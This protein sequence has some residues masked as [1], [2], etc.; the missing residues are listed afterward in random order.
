MIPKPQP[1]ASSPYRASRLELLSLPASKRTI[2]NAKRKR[3][4]VGAVYV[5]DVENPLDKDRGLGTSL[6]RLR[7]DLLVRNGRDPWRRTAVCAGVIWG[8]K[9]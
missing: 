9:A 1:P 3:R 6:T 8:A 2:R 7:N 4:P 5:L